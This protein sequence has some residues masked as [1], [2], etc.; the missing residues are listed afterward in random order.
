MSTRSTLHLARPD[1]LT[2]LLPMAA[3]LHADRGAP[4]DPAHLTAALAPLLDGAPHGA[5]WLV[6]PRRA[7]V[8]FVTV[9]F[10]WSLDFGGM[11]ATVEG[12][13]VRPTVRGRGI[14]SEALNLL[15]GRLREAGVHAIL[16]ETDADAGTDAGGTPPPAARLWARSGFQ[17]RPARQRMVRAL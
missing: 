5:V 1:D 9:S 4:D 3:A 17:R 15:A 14:A 7:P 6:G 12:I 2:A 8:G 11:I 16:A 13:F 10:G